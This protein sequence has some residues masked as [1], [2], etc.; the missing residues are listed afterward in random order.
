LGVS[1]VLAEIALRTMPHSWSG[2]PDPPSASLS[3]M[4]P[5]W[6]A[7]WRGSMRPHPILGLEHAP[8]VDLDVPLPS[9]QFRFRTNNLGLRRDDDVTEA[10]PTGVR[11]VLVLGDSHTDGC[12]D[13][14]ESFSA[15]LEARLRA[16][17]STRIEVLNAGV[18]T[19]SPTQELFWFRTRGIGLQPDLV[20]LVFYP[21]NDA[22]DMVG[23]GPRLDFA[24]GEVAEPKRPLLPR[25]RT[26]ALL[27]RAADAP[28]LSP[29]LARVGLA[30]A[31]P[32][33]GYPAATLGE[34]FR[35]CEGCYWQTLFQAARAHQD[36]P[37]LHAAAE[38][39]PR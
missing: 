24:T 38:G 6:E 27:R 28:P 23:P 20:I 12:V 30:R 25:L 29:W 22:A 31:A 14:A 4:P 35:V 2:T 7:G 16:A 26:L 33:H 15:R 32:G 11:R 21:G 8:D 34:V 10:K 5:G 37:L 3:W 36:P 17:S 18:L 9:G 1:L 39:R 19:Y 13:N